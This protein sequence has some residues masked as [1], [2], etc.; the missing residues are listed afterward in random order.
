MA[1]H[2]KGLTIIELL[3]VI[4]LLTILSSIV[5]A[6]YPNITDA[7]RQS[8]TVSNLRAIASAM[9][10]YYMDHN[11]YP[12]AA[13]IHGLRAIL[14]PVYIQRLPLID[15]WG[16]EFF[17]SSNA[18]SYTIGSGGKGWDGSEALTSSPIGPTTSVTSDI[19]MTNGSFTQF[20]VNNQAD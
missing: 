2:L 16:E 3:V 17:V 12:N 18:E 11:S 7:G 5:I 6:I 4:V 19:I 20:P 10:M 13:D 14:E 15:G 8:T 1:N 9:S